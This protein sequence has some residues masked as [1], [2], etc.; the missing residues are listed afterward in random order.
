MT[1]TKI[2]GFLFAAMLGLASAGIVSGLD[3]KDLV[4]PEQA[5]SLA[6]GEKPVLAQFKDPRPQLLP[7]NSVLRELVETIRLELNPSVMVETLHIY[8]KPPE[9][10]RNAW[11]AREEIELY[12]GVLALSTLAGLQYFSQSRGTMRTFYETSSV[13]DGPSTKKPVTDPVYARPPSALTIYSR[14]KD[15][16]FGDNIYQ[17]DYYSVPGAIIFIQ[18]NLTSLSYGILRAVGK[19]NL[20]SI[21][22]V[23]DADDYLLVYAGSMAKAASL[24]GMNTRIGDSF[25]NRADAVVHWFSDRAD[26]AYKWAGMEY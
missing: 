12:N 4:S 21:V 5:V 19:N 2:V 23:L 6:A 18:Q 24:P 1:R 3:L 10:G 25:A 13:I 8:K 20:R 9:A 15:L 26:R 14:Q 7:R 11:N 22:A 17:Y 16:T